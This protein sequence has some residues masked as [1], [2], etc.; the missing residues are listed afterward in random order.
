MKSLIFISSLFLFSVRGECQL[1]HMKILVGYNEQEVSKYMD[2]LFLLKIN[3]YYKID[4][5]SSEDGDLILSASYALDDESFYKC[6][7]MIALFTRINGENICTKQRIAGAEKYTE[8]NLNY[9]KDKFTY[10][11]P[12]YWETTMSPPYKLTASFE[13]SS[14]S[15]PSYTLTYEIDK[16]KTAVKLTEETINLSVWRKIRPSLY[17]TIKPFNTYKNF[18]GETINKYAI[19]TFHYNTGLKDYDNFIGDKV[20]EV[21]CQQKSF[22]LIT[23]KLLDM[24][25][26]TTSD[27]PIPEPKWEFVK[28]SMINFPME[29]VCK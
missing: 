24:W 22:M 23:V 2:S 15:F 14:G 16:D 29:E 28:N 26:N 18:V 10:I 5:K 21:N 7:V 11:R 20:F 13:K 6:F 27:K 3:P 9:V 8:Y 19:R 25:G 4:R 1:S 17:I 12:G